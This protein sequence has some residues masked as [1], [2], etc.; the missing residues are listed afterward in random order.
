MDNICLTC[1]FWKVIKPENNIGTCSSQER[2]KENNQNP[3][4]RLLS[5][6]RFSC[7]H[8]KERSENVS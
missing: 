3:E 2:R 4:Y 7:K 5:H 8:H 6:E 1:I